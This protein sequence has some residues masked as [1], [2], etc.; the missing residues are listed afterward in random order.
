MEFLSDPTMQFC[1]G[2]PITLLAVYIFLSGVS[3][4]MRPRRRRTRPGT[5]EQVAEF[6]AYMDECI[7]RAEER[8]DPPF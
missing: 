1:I 8:D 5:P 6:R 7:R 2:A 3:W 4:G